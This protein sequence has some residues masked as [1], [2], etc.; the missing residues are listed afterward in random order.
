MWQGQRSATCLVR[1]VIPAMHAVVRR[2][3]SPQQGLG[4]LAPPVERGAA[5]RDARL[6]ELVVPEL[7]VRVSV[8]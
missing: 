7:R 5:V 4:T 2:D 6:K 1:L 3:I 8:I